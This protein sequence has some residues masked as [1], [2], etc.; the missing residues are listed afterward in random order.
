LPRR[1]TS[2]AAGALAAALLAALS[3]PAAAQDAGSPPLRG[4]IGVQDD[5]GAQPPPASRATKRR[6]QSQ[7]SGFEPG[8]GRDTV[9]P[10]NNLAED[11]TLKPSAPA[12][13][14]PPPPLGG[15]GDE[16]A[17]AVPVVPGP[18]ITEES[19]EPLTGPPRVDDED[20]EKRTL[21]PKGHELDPYVPIGM[22]LGSFLLFTDAELGTILTDNVL[23]TRTD[24]QSDHA[25]EFAPNV[26]LES[27]WARHFLS[28][29]FDSDWSWYN[30]FPVEDDRIY[31]ATL[32]GRLDVTRRT[33][34]GLELEQSQTQAGRNSVSITDIAGAQT[35]VHEKHITA[36][37]DHTFNRLTLELEGTASDYNYDDVAGTI[38]DPTVPTGVPV[39][40]IRDYAENELKLRGT[41]QLNSDLAAFVEG[42]LTEDDFKQ[43]ISVG[44]INRNS[45]GFEALSGLVFTKPRLTGEISVGWGQLQS[46][47]ASL[48]PVEGFLLNADLIWMPTPITMMEFLARTNVDTTTL[49]DALGAV[50]RFYELSLQHAF[51]RFLVMRGF[52]SYEIADYAESSLVDQRVKE[53]LS[54]EYYFNPTWSVY[55]RYEHTDFFST[56]AFSGFKENEVRIGMRIRH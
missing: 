7:K 47:D 52:V 12:P 38:F 10:K 3:A 25:F 24:T 18:G 8:T 53:G 22:R 46:I 32:R 41:Y 39:Q 19:G 17:E 34:L 55:A 43:P 5:A 29:E 35:N 56:D 27:N 16:T 20:E 13:P 15:L 49:V 50:D 44:G 11:P 40:D 26:R 28:A 23:A 37:A 9:L 48:A 1:H 31:F 14:A 36:G 51:W 30:D 42:S 4:S 2:S 21:P 6:Q 54:A 45:S 33:H